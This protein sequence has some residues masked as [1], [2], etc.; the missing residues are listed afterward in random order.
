MKTAAIYARVSTAGQARDGSSL[1]T[2]TDACKQYAQAKGYIVAKEVREDMSGASLS[3]PG[4]DTIRDMVER[5]EVGAIIVYD[6]DRLSRDLG[7]L[8]LLC[9][10]FE[11]N[12][13][14]LLFVNAP[15]ENTPEGMMLSQMRGMFAQYER[16]KIAERSRRG[17][18]R[19]AKDGRVV[20]SSSMAP[21]GYE[22]V[23]GE[24]RFQVL[25]SEARWVVKMFEWVVEEHLS[26][27]SVAR[28]LQDLGIP[29]KRNAASWSRPA[30]RR[31]LHNPAYTGT[32]YF[33]T[34]ERVVPTNHRYSNQP[35]REKST[36]AARPRDEWIGITIPAL[37]CPEIYHEVS[38]RLKLNKENN[39]PR[40]KNEYLLR[41]ILR[42]GYCETKDKK[43]VRLRTRPITSPNR[44][45]YTQYVCTGRDQPGRTAACKSP[46]L[47]AT[48]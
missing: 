41:G 31:I 17:K 2:Q 26:L 44:Q 45:P 25:E 36:T 21:Y 30:V 10:E 13:A 1:D 18:E 38:R 32:W 5:R 8:M 48:K 28:R 47:Q 14:D 15:H 46:I 23:Q 20:A 12:R 40:A 39:M 29:T 34:S 37:I 9:E 22:L 33:N 4:L 11:R 42:C 16:S 35:K 7:H 19:K 6:P 24:G 3:R 27:G 43:G